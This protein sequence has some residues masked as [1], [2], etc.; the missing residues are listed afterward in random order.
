[1]YLFM[2]CTADGYGYS[3]NT[4]V[5]GFTTLPACPAPNF[6]WPYVENITTNSAEILFDFVGTGEVNMIIGSPGFLPGEGDT[7]FNITS[8][9]MITGLE[10]LTFYDVYIYQDCE[11]SGNGV[12][13]MDGPEEFNTL[14]DAPGV[15]CADP[16]ILNNNLPWTV[17]EQ[18]ICG[19]S[20]NVLTN[21][22]GNYAGYE[23]IV[24]AYLSGDRR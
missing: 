18:T 12:S 23:E 22:C 1:M 8:P 14:T 20:N 4:G 19:Y 5:L 6:V 3:A 15:S 2:D 21:P 11:G 24:F 16:I 17:E 10:P 13:E 7:V 9:Y